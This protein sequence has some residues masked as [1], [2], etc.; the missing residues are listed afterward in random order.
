MDKYMERVSE[1][2]EE[3]DWEYWYLTLNHE[4]YAVNVVCRHGNPHDCYGLDIFANKGNDYLQLKISFPYAED[5]GD[6]VVWDDGY[7]MDFAFGTWEEYIAALKE[8]IDYW[9]H[10]IVKDPM[11]YISE[12]VL[13]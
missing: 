11:K 13:A 4:G 7:V 12:E 3:T 8:Q 1:F 9:K 2:F 10:E 6:D 5:V